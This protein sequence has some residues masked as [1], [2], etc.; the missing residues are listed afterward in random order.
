MALMHYQ[1]G[2]T[3]SGHL[4]ADDCVLCRNINSLTECQIL[5]DDLNSLAQCKNDWQMKFNVFKC[6]SMRREEDC[7]HFY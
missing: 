5:Q 1:N 4:F 7:I 2:W 6:Y 3:I